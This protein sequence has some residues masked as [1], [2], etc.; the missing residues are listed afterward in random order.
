MLNINVDFY[1]VYMMFNFEMKINIIIKMYELSK[2]N[3]VQHMTL[4]INHGN[5]ILSCSQF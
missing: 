4:N 1:V 3:S 5:Q 2:C